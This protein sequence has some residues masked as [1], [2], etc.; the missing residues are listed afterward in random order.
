MVSSVTLRSGETR[1]SG[2]AGRP[3]YRVYL[4]PSAK[5][6][7]VEFNGK[8]VADSCEAMLL[9]ETRHLPVYYFPRQD[10][11]WSS[12]E[13]SEHSTY[14]PFK[15]E[16]AYWDVAVRGRREANALWSY[17]QP[18][19]EVP[20]LA[21]Y[22]AFYWGKM[23]RWFEEDEEVFVHPRDPYVRL[24]MLDSHRRVQVELDGNM[25]AD[26]TQ[27]VFLFETGLPT[28]YYFPRGDVRMESLIDSDTFTRCPYKGMA[29]HFH[30]RS[31]EQEG[32]VVTGDV[33]WSYL[34]PATEVSRIAGL[35]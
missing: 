2:Y 24:D 6:L 9:Y 4:E 28:R 11:D 13:V 21:D 33:A 34:E 7:R 29:A 32:S 26:S 3:E 20:E 18:F 17:P 35:L 15:G 14:C 31:T 25:V 8:V 22:C 27:T 1:E 23:D 19:S 12:F 5:R 30:S 10:I 16:A